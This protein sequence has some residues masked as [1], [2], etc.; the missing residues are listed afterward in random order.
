MNLQIKIESTV[1]HPQGV[2]G[3]GVDIV[4]ERVDQ[5]L[6]D[7]GFDVVATYAGIEIVQPL[8]A[9]EVRGQGADFPRAGA[10]ARQAAKPD[11]D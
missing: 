6:K 7:L 8:S 2:F 5:V 10:L 3:V 4:Q 11:R 9:P 1:K